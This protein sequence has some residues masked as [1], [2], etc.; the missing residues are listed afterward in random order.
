[1]FLKE[2]Q[3][4]NFKSFGRKITVPFLQGYTAITGPNGAGKSNIADAI[5]F[6]LGPKSSKAIRAGKLTDLIWN[7][8]KDRRG[9]DS[10][11][12]SL[13]FDNSD[14][15]IP[16]EADEVKLTRYVGL[17]PSVEGGYNSYFY[18]NDRKSSLSEF[19]SLLAHAR[20]SAEGYNLVQQGDVQKIVSMS[21]IERRRILDNIAGITKFDD[22]IT[23]AEGKRRETE[24]NLERIRIILDEI[25]RQIKQLEADRDGALKYKE[26][27]GRM[28]TAKAQLAYK[29]REL[30]ERQIVGTKE[31]I[32]K[33]EADKAKL[34]AQ[35]AEL[36]TLFDAA[37]ARLN[38]LEQEMAERGG[39]EARQLK[40]KLDGLRI[41]R[42]RATDGI[43]TSKEV[44]KQL[45]VEAGETNRDQTKIQKETDA[46]AREREKVDA[47]VGELDEQIKAA[48]KDLHDVDELA[49]KSDAKV[50]GIQKQII[51]LNN[52]IDQV[53]ERVKG[54]VLEGDRTK[55]AMSRLESEITQIEESRK[56]YQVEYDDADWQLKELRTSTKES[57]KSLQ[58]LQQE[59]HEKRAEEAKLAREQAE[60]QTAILSL[61]RG[62]AQLKAE[63]D[64]A[65]NMKRGYTSA[66]S[67]ILECRE[68]G[69]IKG[70]HGTVAQLAH[71]ETQYETAIV[72]SAGARMQALIVDDDSVAAQCIDY[73]KKRRIG[74]ATF[75][76][77][78]K[79]LVGKPRGKAILVAKEC[80]GFAI[81]LCH[82]DE[83]YRDAFFYVFGDTLVVQT[84]DEARKW[85]GGVRLVTIEGELI[86][87]SGAM[88][89]G[90]MERSTV[91]FGPSVA[92]EM[93][94]IAEKLREAQAQGETVA[95]RLD[96]LRKALLDLEG[97][98]KD[99]GGRS[100][101]VEVKTSTL[102]AKR[103]EFTAKVATADKDLR[104]RKD[105]FGE[106]QK[107]ATRIEEDLTKFTKSLEELKAKRDERKKAVIAATPQ[108]ISS[109]MK[110]LM[111]RRATLAEELSG[112]RSKLEAMATQTTFLEERRTEIGTRLT[113]L[114]GQRKDHEKRIESFQESLGRLETEIRGLEKTEAQMGRKIKDLQDA[115]D[116][117]Y[118][119][120]TD[121]EA[122]LDK[123]THKIETK[124]DFLLKMQT[125][126]KVQ[127]EQLADAEH[128]MKEM[129]IELQEGRLPSLE[130][131]KTTIADCEAAINALGPINLRALEDYDAQQAR[132]VELKDEFKRLEGQREEL[133][134][135]VD[136]LTDKKKEG[137][138]KIFT[139]IN[140]NFG[141]VYAELTEGGEAELAL[142]YPEKPFEG[143]LILK[144]KPAHKKALRLEALSG[145]ERSLASMALIFAIQE[146][147][148]SPFY[149]LDEI[150]QN[151]DAV[152][153]EK[154]ARMIRR[155]AATAQF[156]QI[157]LRKVSLK[158]ADHLVGVTMT[159]ESLSEVIMRVNLADIEDEKP[160]EVIPA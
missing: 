119:E 143:G 99:S 145:G 118:K 44:L 102:E 87:A 126:L 32:A 18:I 122:D 83:K 9:A 69:S 157:S 5:L 20:I 26:L 106:A 149:L 84:L 29:N 67:A 58:K 17:S 24:E 131:L 111:N 55:E 8:G 43:E 125:E 40:E 50:L 146:Y 37:I 91:K 27:N 110:E 34:E 80:L 116:A 103:K 152:N 79:M 33:H 112:L 104:D 159:P 66:V 51:A 7:G 160:T 59:F 124:E 47:R 48:D 41:E 134:H 136:E 14:R 52:E 73:L 68:T 155:N 135:L 76:P 74:R 107:T 97:E 15:Q 19:D 108:Q 94:K 129:A 35:K 61:T 151:L 142:E 65:E 2:I 105:R 147:D 148:P 11:Q 60:L 133:I 54:I 75:L 153:A 98:I 100:G 49:S 154:V 114:D 86:E 39:E 123:V 78:T 95:N 101:V 64:V 144:V 93:E 72:T 53:E 92:S 4:E 46:L 140:D 23:Q 77:L 90:D 63:A 25:D 85:M 3:M 70:I 89:G 156:V 13:L 81:D 121:R 109:R 10:C 31:Q 137:L 88:V 158:E 38:E 45:R 113:A 36:R 139:S 28:S 16:V 82:F 1:L 120:K 150:D 127:E 62:Y 141:R 115:R 117:A 57:G 22:D 130:E 30:I 128:M 132:A 96:E 12:V 42:A 56:A 138:A 6:V 71:V 21:S